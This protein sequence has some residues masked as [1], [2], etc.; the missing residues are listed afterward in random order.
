MDVFQRD[1]SKKDAICKGG[2]NMYFNTC[3]QCGANLDPGERCDCEEQ[4][5]KNTEKIKKF[6]ITDKKTNQMKFRLEVEHEK[7]SCY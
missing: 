4:R 2:L 5:N 7:A 3:S 6:L 1:T